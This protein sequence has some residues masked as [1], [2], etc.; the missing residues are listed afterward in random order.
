MNII[1]SCWFFYIFPSVVKDIVRKGEGLKRES[2]NLSTIKSQVGGWAPQVHHV[3]G[4]KLIRRTYLLI[5]QAHGWCWIYQIAAESKVLIV[6]TWSRLQN[7]RKCKVE[8][9]PQFSVRGAG[10]WYILRQC[11]TTDHHQT[12]PLEQTKHFQGNDFYNHFYFYLHP[13][14]NEPN[15]FCIA[16]QPKT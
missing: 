14:Y 4:S 16:L 13:Y 7:I 5:K 8:R 11:P 15:T 2:V 12:S 6:P 3:H 9:T 1:V 10:W